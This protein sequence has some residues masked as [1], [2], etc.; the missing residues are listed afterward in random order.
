MKTVAIALVGLVSTYS[1]VHAEGCD[2]YPFIQGINVE[3]VKG[4]IRIISTAEVSVSFDDIDSIKDARDEATL[5]AKSLISAF[6]SEGIRSDQ[7]INKAVQ[8]T[9]SMQGEAKTAAR[10]EVTERVKRL[11]SSSQA[12]LRGVVPLGE[13]YTKG[14]VF[15]VTVGIKPETIGAAE[16]LAGGISNSLANQPPPGSPV[17]PRGTT[18]PTTQRPSGM[19]SFSNTEGLGKF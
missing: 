15:R 14:R 11:A 17:P 10:K 19:D 16:N 4:G 13:C 18:P 2:D 7:A 1:N 8:E 3:D 12:L 5:E 6:M 9:K